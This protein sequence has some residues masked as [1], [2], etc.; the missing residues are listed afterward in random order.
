VQVGAFPQPAEAASLAAR[1]RKR[2]RD[3]Y[4]VATVVNGRIGLVSAVWRVE[5]RACN[6]KSPKRQR[7]HETNRRDQFAVKTRRRSVRW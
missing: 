6:S 4:V 5:S 3:A 2:N 7:G 1:L